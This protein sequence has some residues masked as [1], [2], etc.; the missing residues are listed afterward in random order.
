MKACYECGVLH[1][2]AALRCELCKIKYTEIRKDWVN[3]RLLQGTC[4]YCCSPWLGKT[5]ACKECLENRKTRAQ[6][7]KAGRMCSE[8]M[9]PTPSPQNSKCIECIEKNRKTQ[10]RRRQTRVESGN[11]YM[12]GGKNDLEHN[13]LC[14][15]CIYKAAAYAWLG[16]SFRWEELKTLLESQSFKCAYTSQPISIGEDATIDHIL[17]RSRGGENIIE[18]LQWVSWKANWS[19]GN[20]THEEFIE[21][22]YAVCETQSLPNTGSQPKPSHLPQVQPT[23]VTA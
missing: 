23:A 20:M 19:K 9:G 8:C 2:R 4:M 13:R 16:S 22:C 1:T 6:A 21:M 12:C 11:C 5:K 3:R 10:R 7:L 18:N 17:P 14:S 15:V